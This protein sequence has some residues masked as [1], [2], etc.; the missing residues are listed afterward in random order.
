M[1]SG[2][3]VSTFAIEGTLRNPGY[4]SH[5]QLAGFIETTVVGN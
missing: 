2:V 3:F 4:C 5:E 1:Q